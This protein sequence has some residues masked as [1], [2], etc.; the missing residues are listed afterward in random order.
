V[1]VLDRHLDA[2]MELSQARLRESEARYKVIV[3]TAR[4]AIWVIDVDGV[5]TFANAELVAILGR[6]LDEILGQPAVDFLDEQTIA[7][8]TENLTGLRPGDGKRLDFNFV[9]PDGSEAWASVSLAPMQDA[10]GQYAG[11]LVMLTDITERRQAEIRLQASEARLEE[12]QRLALIGD[13]AYDVHSRTLTCSDGVFLVIGVDPSAGIASFDRFM[14]LVHP[15]DRCLANDFLTGVQTTFT[16]P[17]TE[18]RIITPGG[19]ERW[20]MLHATPVVDAN[21]DVT[22]MWGTMQDIT[23]RKVS[24]QRF[25]HLALHDMLTGLPN[26]TLFNDR[27]DQALLRRDNP[28][29]VMLVDLDGLKAINDGLGHSAGDALLVAVSDRLSSALRPSDT[30]A[31]F[32]GDEFTILVEGAGELEAMAAADRLLKALA[33]PMAVE[34]RSVVAQA[35]IG[36]ALGAEGPRG[37]DQ[38]L[39]NADAA[40]YAAKRRGGGRY[41]LFD[42]GLHATVVE[43]M[44]LECDLRSVELGVEM[45]LHYQ[46]LVDLHDGH[47]TGFEALLR[48]NH[49]ERGP[50]S[51][52]DFIPIAEQTGAIVPIGRWVVEEAA[53]Q[54]GLWQRRYPAAAGLAMNVNVSARQLVDPDI[55]RDVAGALDASGLDPALLTLEIT[56]TISIA[57][58]DEIG[59]TLQR[60]SGLGVRISVDD[61]G[62]GYSSLRHL[63]RFPVDEIKIDQSFV[64]RLGADDDDPGVALAIIRLAHS[65]N[66]DVVAE[67]IEREDQLV[68]LRDAQCVRGQGYHFWRPLDVTTVEELLE[69][70]PQP[71]LPNDL[72]RADLANVR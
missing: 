7:F 67:G 57:D 53:R 45:T 27:L 31:R 51:P 36:I 26:R 34:G 1:S 62:T 68:Q 25:V 4:E 16:E 43:R 20:L 60:L 41:E 24:E 9:R 48:W 21:G 13:W 32:G 37:A 22:E 71:G 28:V 47:L 49:P 17:S 11:V 56:E 29:A 35:S 5:T 55:V 40:M 2:E 19:E 15:G 6:P 50:I 8:A 58:E 72:T 42:A 52:A 33:A 69:Q 66:L 39:R 61:F 38:L 44:S 12:A 59:E 30:V 10:G 14:L 54:C 63:D 70:L 65:L 64:A 18:L 3:E 46:P 23:E